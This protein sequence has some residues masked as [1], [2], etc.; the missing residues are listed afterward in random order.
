MASRTTLRWLAG[1]LIGVAATTALTTGAAVASSSQLSSVSM[2]IEPWIG[3]APWYIAQQ[4]GYFK[5][6]G[7]SVNIVNFQQ[8]ADRNAA[9]VAGKTN[10]SNIDTGRTIQ[11]AVKHEPAVPLMLEDDSNGADAILSVKS[12]STA[13]QLKGESVAYEYGTTSD[14]LLHYYLLKHH[15]PFSSVKPVNVPAADAGTL[16]IA[17]KDKVVVTYQP[18]IG[19]ATSGPNASNVH[20]FFSSAQAP[21]LISDFLVANKGWLAGHAKQARELVESWNAAISF[22]HSHR[23][24]AVAIMAKGVGA[25]PSS[26][27]STLAGVILYSVSDNSTLV[28][29]GKLASEYTGI[30]NTLKAMGVISHTVSLGSVANFTYLK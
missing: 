10:V 3:Y 9:L 24:Q 23:T 22:Y 21:G 28:S 16:L 4:E 20:V 11:F 15:L 5:R 26:L 25:T 2:G 13:S 30:G 17:G 27:A 18:Y 7:L 8:D 19:E 14:L 29:S 12:V 6:Y 1:S